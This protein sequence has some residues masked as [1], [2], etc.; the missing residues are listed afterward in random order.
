ME[1][2]KIDFSFNF[3]LFKQKYNELCD[4][5]DRLDPNVKYNLKYKEYI[6]CNKNSLIVKC[7]ERLNDKPNFCDLDELEDLILEYEKLINKIVSCI[8][9]K[10]NEVEKCTKE[11]NG[12]LNEY[13]KK[14]KNALEANFSENFENFKK[15]YYKY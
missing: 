14:L 1:I 4:L 3:E 13:K 15:S 8:K 6:F 2:E 12:M 11:M 10:F 7:I 9:T 5:L